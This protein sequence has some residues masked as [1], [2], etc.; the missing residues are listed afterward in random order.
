MGHAHV[1]PHEHENGLGAF[2][3]P[4]VSLVMLVAGMI[5]TH[6]GFSL[7]ADHP[8]LELLWYVIAF[9]PVGVPV[10]REACE[11]MI[12]KDIFNE[13]TLMSVACLGAF[14]IGEYPEAVGVMLFYSIGETLQDRAVDKAT[15]DISHLLSLKT[16]KA[17]L[18]I[19]GRT[20]DTDPK[21]VAPGAM[22]EVFPGE[23]VPLDG[24]L[25]SESALFDT[26]ALTGESMPRQLGKGDEVLAGMISLQTAV[27]VRTTREYGESALSRILKMVNEAS[28]RKAPT[29]L[30]IRRFA[31]IYTPTVLALAALLV[32]VPA[33][34][35]AANP[36]FHYVF[37]SWLERALVFLVISCPCALVISVPLGY[38]AGIGMASRKG[39]LFKGGN[40]LDAI[41]KIKRV[42]F[43]KT[44]TLTTGRFGVENVT[45]RDMPAPEFLAVVASAESAS[46]HP[47]AVA[48]K[49]YARE[50]GVTVAK[51]DDVKEFP[52]YGIKAS[53]GGKTII[54]GNHKLMEKE[55][56]ALPESVGDIDATSIICAIDGRFAGIVTFSDTLKPDAEKAIADLRDLGVE[57][58]VMLSGDRQ[59]AV[60]KFADKLGLDEARG[61]LLPEDKAAY[62]EKISG[63]NDGGTAFVGDGMNDSPVLAMSDVGI[64]M[65]ALGSDMAVEAADMVL[66]TDSPSSVATAI[67]IGRKARVIIREN[68]IGAIGVKVAILVLG[69]LGIANLWAAVFADVGVALLA[70]LNS[71]R[72][73]RMRLR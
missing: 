42:A 61:N 21:T 18:I 57:K 7:F 68:I 44:G 32:A 27:R 53:V 1:E 63:R 31:R 10:F 47:L 20:A 34:V 39:I 69:M 29:E 5:M 25:E 12:S 19:D 23:R 45:S 54:A 35:G 36:D 2:I 55:R 30:F 3:A 17:H 70:V 59:E 15:R 72:I 24:V 43:D 64:A 66:Q 6:T 52:G 51:P 62:V 38:F 67:R 4:A 46:S 11:E 56:I 26:S 73:L 41:A 33:I 8:F 71:M 37:S 40:Y 14:C 13:F 16:D 50:K 48:L 9:L 65:G 22:I 28:E 49:N 60:D 58:I